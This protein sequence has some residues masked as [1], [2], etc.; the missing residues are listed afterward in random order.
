MAD[1]IQKKMETNGIVGLVCGIVKD[2]EL[3]WKKAYGYADLENEIEVKTDTI[4]L[5]ASVSKT[6]TATAAMI[7]YERGEIDL[8]TDINEYLPFQVIHPKYSDIPITAKM[9]LTHTSSISD[10]SYNEL[11]DSVLYVREDEEMEY[12]LASLLEE[13]FTEDGEFY[14]PELCFSDKKPGIKYDYSNVGTSLLGYLVEVISEQSL[15]DF[16]KENIFK[17]LGMK[18]TSW[19]LKN[20]DLEKVTLPYY[21]SEN[22]NGHYESPDY[23]DGMLRS[24]VEDMA[25]F[26]IMFIQNGEYKGKRILQEKTAELMKDTHFEYKEEGE[27]NRIGLTWYYLDYGDDESYLGHAGSEEGVTTSMFYEVN[28]EVGVLVF[29]NTSNAEISEIEDYLF[30]LEL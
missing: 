19:F 20:L 6:V 26:L 15:E 21:D 28:S 14:D 5:L 11:E 13:Y 23:P 12:D 4:F 1:F 27:T 9:L 7:L 29:C 25:R 16:C 30:Q 2:G 3:A 24:T 17:P 18:N 8:E 22:T 10:S